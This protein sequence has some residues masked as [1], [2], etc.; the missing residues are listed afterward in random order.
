VQLEVNLHEAQEEINSQKLI[1]SLLNDENKPAN[2]PQ[3]VN[4]K[5]DKGPNTDR[6]LSHPPWPIKTYISQDTLNYEQYE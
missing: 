1:I 3:Q 2:Q 6:V 5:I 4:L